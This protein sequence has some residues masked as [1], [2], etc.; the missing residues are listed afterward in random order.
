MCAL[1]TFKNG[2]PSTNRLSTSL[3]SF[4]AFGRLRLSEVH[5]FSL[6][7]KCRHHILPFPTMGMQAVV[8][9]IRKAFGF[10]PMI[11]IR[12]MLEKPC[13][14]CIKTT[15]FQKHTLTACYRWHQSRSSI[16]VPGT[17]NGM[18]DVEPGSTSTSNGAITPTETDPIREPQGTDALKPRFAKVELFSRFLPAADPKRSTFKTKRSERKNLLLGCF[19]IAVFVLLVNLGST[20]VFVTKWGSQNGIGTIFKGDCQ[21]GR[22]LSTWMHLLINILSTLLLWASNLCMQLL[23]APTRLEVDKAHEKSIWLDIGVPS[24]RNLRHIARWRGLVWSILGLSSIPLHF[25]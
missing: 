6:F 25:L 10:H 2:G 17:E 3:R 9:G 19:A 11:H 1:H 23:A 13:K 18:N 21:H 4:D 20:I 5:N 16:V 22:R 7:L 24:M 15:L 14:S 8:M 12:S